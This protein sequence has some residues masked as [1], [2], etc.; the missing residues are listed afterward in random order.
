[1]VVSYCRYG[2]VRYGM[3]W[4]G[5]AGYVRGTGNNQHYLPNYR[6][7]N[8][9]WKRGVLGKKTKIGI[10][11]ISACKPSVSPIPTIWELI[12]WWWLSA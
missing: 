3:V 2:M 5:A 10:S 11:V 9:R 12:G 8:V 4:Y 7:C 6:P 1:M